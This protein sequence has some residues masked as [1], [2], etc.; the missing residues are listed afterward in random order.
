MKPKILNIEMTY[1]E[2]KEI[3]HALENGRL[4]EAI[5]AFISNHSEQNLSRDD[6][7]SLALNKAVRRD[8]PR[9]VEDILYE[10]YTQSILTI[11]DS[12]EFSPLSFALAFRKRSDVLEAIKEYLDE[13]Q[14]EL[15]GMLVE[16]EGEDF[17]AI[18]AVV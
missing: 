14:E 12:T 2:F 10:E 4:E 16:L 13:H 6:V 18:R 5:A 8:I 1:A 7:L 9:T 15:A 3:R 11:M 17:L